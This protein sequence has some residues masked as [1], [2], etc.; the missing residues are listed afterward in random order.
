MRTGPDAAPHEEL[1]DLGHDAVGQVAQQR[2]GKD[3][4]EFVVQE[5]TL[6]ANVGNPTAL[7]SS[8]G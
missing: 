8:R 3:P 2:M 7:G 1:A 4:F 5:A 6:S